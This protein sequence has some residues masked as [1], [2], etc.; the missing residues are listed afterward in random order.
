[1]EKT[2]LSVQSHVAHGNVGNRA[3][4]F[5]LQVLGW[6]VDIVNTVN[7]SNHSGQ[8]KFKTVLIRFHY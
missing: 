7:F 2:V 1:M 6:D 3:A 5:P 4:A 8:L